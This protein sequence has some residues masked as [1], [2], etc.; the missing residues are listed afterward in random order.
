MNV[1]ST[2][3]G[4]ILSLSLSFKP[5][6]KPQLSFPLLRFSN[7]HLKRI[8]KSFVV[9]NKQKQSVLLSVER[10]R[11]RKSSCVTFSTFLF[12]IQASSYGIFCVPQ[13]SIIALLTLFSN[14]I[15]RNPFHHF[16]ITKSLQNWS[17]KVRKTS[18]NHKSRFGVV[19]STRVKLAHLPHCFATLVKG[20]VKNSEFS[21]K[22]SS[23]PQDLYDH[24]C[25]SA[26]AEAAAWMCAQAQFSCRQ[27]YCRRTFSNSANVRYRCCS[28]ESCV[29]MQ[30][31]PAESGS[32]HCRNKTNV[33]FTNFIQK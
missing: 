17:T 22:G 18:I 7:H 4:S 9:S 10:R 20:H 3:R 6:L 30:L 21:R 27:P 13:I 31:C 19:I 24:I 28:C 1:A 33:L 8:L 32:F 25:S 12:A 15:L 14:Q 5:Q 11:R 2:A 16:T 23:L 26:A 29:P